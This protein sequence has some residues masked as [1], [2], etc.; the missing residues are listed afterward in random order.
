MQTILRIVCILALM[1]GTPLVVT[2][3]LPSR[4][5]PGPIGGW[6]M[7][8][9]LTLWDRGMMR[10]REEADRAGK[11]VARDAG[12][13]GWALTSY[14]WEDNEIEIRLIVIGFHGNVS[15]ENCNIARR[16]FISELTGYSIQRDAALVR[17]YLPEQI[18]AWFSHIGFQ[19]KTRDKKLGEKMA[20]IIFV[21]VIL[22]GNEGAIT[23]K[24]RIVTFDAPSKP[25]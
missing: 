8:E 20:R 25:F 7:N 3:A 18:S 12:K 10:A 1:S 11:R 16:S 19:S 4:A 13:G 17:K 6:L 15:H 9:P 2:L 22:R 5:E 24:E 23:C 21:R 14:N